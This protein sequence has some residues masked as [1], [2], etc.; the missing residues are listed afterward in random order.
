MAGKAKRLTRREYR[1][2]VRS[3][4]NAEQTTGMQFCVYLGP[5]GDDPRGHAE[6]MF[7]NAGLHTRPAILLLVSP[8]ARCVELVTSPEVRERVTDQTCAHAITEM[9]RFFARSDIAGG[10]VTGTQII[11]NAVGS[12]AAKPSAEPFPDLIED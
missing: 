7:E 6:A 12:A 3:V 2:V 4:K 9:T 5:T 8:E 11:Q 1:R 10:I